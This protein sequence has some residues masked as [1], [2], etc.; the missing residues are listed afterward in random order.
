MYDIINNGGHGT[1]TTEGTQAEAY[2][3]DELPFFDAPSADCTAFYADGQGEDESEDEE[4]DNTDPDSDVSEDTMG[5]TAAKKKKVSKRTVG[6]TPK[7]DV[8]LA[9]LGLQLA[10]TPFSMPSKRERP[11]GRG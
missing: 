11:I 8:C 7:E 10:K 1:G 2:D 3:I 6:Y 9:G 4:E 5:I